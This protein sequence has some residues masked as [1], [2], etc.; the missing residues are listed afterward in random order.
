MPA[1]RIC[2]LSDH[3]SQLTLLQHTTIDTNNLQVHH[4]GIN[5]NK[6]EKTYLDNEIENGVVELIYVAYSSRVMFCE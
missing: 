3:K 1:I 4:Q 2:D 5:N 6:K